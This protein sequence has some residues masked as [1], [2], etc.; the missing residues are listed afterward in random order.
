MTTELSVP[1][2]HIV[3]MGWVRKD[4][5]SGECTVGVIPDDGI[6]A[7][8]PAGGLGIRTNTGCDFIFPALAEDQIARLIEAQIGFTIGREI[9]TEAELYVGFMRELMV[10]P[11]LFEDSS[12]LYETTSVSEWFWSL[13]PESGPGEWDSLAETKGV[14]VSRMQAL[15]ATGGR[16][17][18][19][20][21]VGKDEEQS[22]TILRPNEYENPITLTLTFDSP[23]V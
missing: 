13:V 3:Q 9:S 22:C 10:T 1:V 21:G 14:M 16:V 11:L 2:S 6:V 4:L 17:R 18:V 5:G 15:L 8:D 12:L 7:Y 23:P 19:G 20:I